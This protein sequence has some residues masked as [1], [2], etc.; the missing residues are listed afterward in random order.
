MNIGQ[1]LSKKYATAFLNVSTFD[2]HDY[3]RVL[4]VHKLLRERREILSL[5]HAQL[6]V[7][8]AVE[9]FLNIAFGECHSYVYLKKMVHL[10]F[11]HRRIILLPQVLEWIAALYVERQQILFFVV[12]SSSVLDADMQHTVV[13]YLERLSTKKVFAEFVI[14]ERLLLGIRARTDALLWEYSAKRQL[15]QIVESVMG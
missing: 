15:A 9:Q 11:H 3:T 6:H 8:E 5:L 13:K 2:M 1:T 14:D 12:A 7:N 4:I 10:L